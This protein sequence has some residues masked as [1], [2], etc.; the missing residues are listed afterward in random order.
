VKLRL[1]TIAHGLMALYLVS[2]LAVPSM[3]TPLPALACLAALAAGFRDWRRDARTGFDHMAVLVVPAAVYLLLL[4]I[5]LIAGT[6]PVSLG[7]HIL[8]GLL[9]L[10]VGLSGVPNR[11]A[12]VRRWLLPAAA[13]G[14]I[15]TCLLALYQ[16]RFLGYLRPY[17][18]LGGGPLGNGAIK[19]GDL[20]AL[21]ALLSLVLVLTATDKARRLLGLAGLFAGV[22]A[23]ALTLTRGGILGF[24]MAA[25]ALGLAL[26]LRY[27]RDAVAG[28]AHD[29]AQAGPRS[30][31]RR[32]TSLL[33]VAFSLLL[34][35][36]AA[37]FMQE[38]F[39]QIE[40]QIQRYLKGDVDSEVGQRL[41]L[42]QAAVRAGQHAPVT[43]TG[44]GRFGEEL[45][46][47][48]AAGDI[49]VSEKLLYRQA[50][51]EYLSALA[52]AGIPGL[53]SLLLM[54][55]AP[56][57]ALVRQIQAGRGSPA[58][59]AAL[60]T[61]TAFAGFALTD[62]MFDRQISVIA[63]FFL[64]AWLLRAALSPAVGDGIGRPG[65]ADP[66]RPQASP[67][68]RSRLSVAIITKNEQHRI[69]RCLQSVDFADQVVV[70][71][72]GSTDDTVAV[73]RRLGAETR[74]T[75]DWPGFGVQKNR[76]LG[77]CRHPWVLSID[78]DEEV[79]AELRESVQA[80]VAGA[81]AASA[82][83]YWIDRTSRFCGQTIRF[84][85]WRNDRVLRLFRRDGG[86]FSDDL[87]HERVICDEPLGHLSGI[88]FHDSVDSIEDAREKTYRYARA[89]AGE[90]RQPRSGPEGGGDKG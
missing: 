15:C 78:A 29:D 49:R 79:S 70:V 83:G 2:V 53:L 75:P 27:R 16:V 4:A 34:L 3:S 58:A 30:G 72:S 65:A 1:E 22:L 63:F 85:L 62:D 33:M 28:P 5:Q 45:G 90:F 59:Y 6:A 40:P 7:S 48:V 54:F 18:W 38:R 74:V 51:S 8:I 32:R 67:L 86:R 87:V 25:G 19:F 23:L 69:E 66:G 50:H 77:M 68:L 61:A 60:V 76:A 89:G 44:F 24:L 39:A 21:Q 55:V 80:I 43:G 57:F 81:G 71:D 88:L 64:N 20:A 10:G 41:V 52:A 11:V 12:D 37:G 42:W 36:S 47:Q 13:L 9:T 73:A 17:G 84:G 26:A 46:R 31:A 35:L 82:N 14:A 56:V